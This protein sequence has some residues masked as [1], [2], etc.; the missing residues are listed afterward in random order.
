MPLGIG[1]GQFVRVVRETRG[2]EGSTAA[3]TVS[4]PGARAFANGLAIGGDPAAIQVDG[5]PLLAIVAVRLIDRE[6]SVA[7][8]AVL[9]RITRSG[10]GLVVVS[11][12]PVGPI[13]YVLPEDVIAADP[14]LPIAKEVA[15]AIIRVAS[16]RAP[17]LAA[18]LPLLRPTVTRRLVSSTALT[19]AVLAALP[20]TKHA[21]LPLL[22]LAQ[23][24]ML[25][26][27]G[28]SRGSVLPRDPQELAV[29]AGPAF[30]G[31]IGLGFGART[32]VRRLPVRGPLVR[33]TVAYAGTWALGT[34][35]RRL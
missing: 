5:D 11:R 28:L 21:Q 34:A 8:V 26:L 25:L 33:A 9:R 12:Q 18:R 31:S 4:G 29:A 20:G 16:D 10:T 24:R 30:A 32:L 23:S 1:I 15:L 14:E 3:I 6:P 13:P 35:Y 19:N 22:T 27:L 2:L 7:E 17:S